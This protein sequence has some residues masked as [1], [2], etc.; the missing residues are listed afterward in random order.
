MLCILL[1]LNSSPL[2]CPFLDLYRGLDLASDLDYTTVYN[3]PN[4]RVLPPSRGLRFEE[5]MYPILLFNNKEVVFNPKKEVV[6]DW[7]VIDFLLN[8]GCKS[9]MQLHINMKCK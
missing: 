5:R 9:H 1:L 6:L 2:S 3:H 4:D 7:L 8:R